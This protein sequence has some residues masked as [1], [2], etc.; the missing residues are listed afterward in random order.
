MATSGNGV[1]FIRIYPISYVFVLN[2]HVMNF[3]TDD[4]VDDESYDIQWNIFSLHEKILLF[5]FCR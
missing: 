2:I 3:E 5:Y 4:A 1:F